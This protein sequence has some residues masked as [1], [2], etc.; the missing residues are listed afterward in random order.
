VV[1]KTVAIFFSRFFS[2]SFNTWHSAHIVLLWDGY[3]CVDG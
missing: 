2:L 3:W 1:V